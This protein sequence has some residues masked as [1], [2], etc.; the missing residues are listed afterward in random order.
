MYKERRLIVAER[1]SLSSK[2]MTK[3]VPTMLL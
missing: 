3:Y 2:M 1:K